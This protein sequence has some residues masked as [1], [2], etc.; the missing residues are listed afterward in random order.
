MT[1]KTTGVT[2]CLAT[3]GLALGLTANAA[4]QP[5]VI[6]LTQTGCQ[7]VESENGTDRGFMPTE[8]ADCETIND[9]SGE[10]RLSEA[11]PLRLSPGKYVFRVTNEDVPYML[12]FY[13]RAESAIERPFLPSTSGGGLHEGV[14]QD[15]E[16]ELEE[17]EYVYSCPLNTTPD[18]VLIVE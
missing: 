15:Y 7:F 9:E 2:A 5:T 3:A 16:I 1:W 12:G 11:E 4:E 14:T 8:K 13:L 17:G 10:Q 6:E 18:Y